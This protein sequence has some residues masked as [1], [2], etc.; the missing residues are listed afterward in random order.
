MSYAGKVWEF[1][2]LRVSWL[3]TVA[4]ASIE[5]KTDLPGG[6]MAIRST[7][8]LAFGSERKT[9]TFELNGIEGKQMQPKFLPGASGTLRVYEA[10]VL[11]RPI[12]LYL[13]PGDSYETQ[14]I[15]LGA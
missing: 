3:A 10:S 7:L 4:N 15:S 5:F 13:K 9:D 6:A 12:G 2:E 8:S 11:A 1:K 14:P